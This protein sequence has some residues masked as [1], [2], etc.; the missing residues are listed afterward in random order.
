MSYVIK[1]K[2]R[3]TGKWMTLTVYGLFHTLEAA[4]EHISVISRRH[5]TSTY[6][7]VKSA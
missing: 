3:E 6:K 4:K 7:A 5:P 1:Q 2:H